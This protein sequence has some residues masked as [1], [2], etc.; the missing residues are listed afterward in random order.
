MEYTL[1]LIEYSTKYGV[2]VSTLRRKIKKSA[3]FNKMVDGKYLL[4]DLEY[5]NLTMQNIAPSKKQKKVAIAP[6][7][8]QSTVESLREYKGEDLDPLLD[9]NFEENVETTTQSRSDQSRSDQSRSSKRS[10]SKQIGS[11]QVGSKQSDQSRS[12]QSRSDQ[13]RSDQSRLDFQ[14]ISELKQA[15]RMILS[16][17]EDQ[18]TTLKSHMV[19][20]KTLNKVL[21]SELKRLE[22]ELQKKTPFYGVNYE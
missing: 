14:S 22:A 2:S 20:L 18:I 15:F 19:D 5:R 4:P 13:S 8:K 7:Q 3:I 1:S 9:T 6:P 21:E 17:K 10:E 16:E 12:D 11:K